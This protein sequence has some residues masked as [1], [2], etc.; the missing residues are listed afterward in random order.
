MILDK[1][2]CYVTAS[3]SFDNLASTRVQVGKRCAEK[4]RML[5]TLAISVENKKGVSEPTSIHLVHITV[6]YGVHSNL[7]VDV[8]HDD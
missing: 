6:D 5:V 7:W 8:L 3:Q 4:A 1:I 2:L